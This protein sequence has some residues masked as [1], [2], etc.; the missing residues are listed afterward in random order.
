[1]LALAE[2]ANGLIVVEPEA[3]VVEQ[4]TTTGA[5]ATGW[6]EVKR[7]AMG[8]RRPLARDAR[9]EVTADAARFDV[10][11]AGMQCEGNYL[12]E[13]VVSCHESD[14]PWPL[15]AK[16]N[17]MALGAFYNGARN[18]FTGVVTPSVG[19]DLPAFYAAAVVPRVAGNAALMVGGID[20][21]VQMVENGALRAVSGTRDWGSDFAAVESGCGAGT[22]VIS[23]GSGDA[24]SD[25]LR[26]Y[27]LPALEAVPASAPLAMS[28]TVMALSSA[29]DGKSVVAVVR[30]ADNAYEVDRVTAS[31][32]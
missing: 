14:D 3:I 19:V 7:V 9:G 8:Q 28:G 23:S 29:P 22:Q 24:A 15:V 11:V 18:S 1:M 20:G 27:E 10:R 5:Q 6:Q 12:G 2:T 4:R 30:G 31:C 17:A 16:A 13:W 21:K 26:A 32:N 25:S